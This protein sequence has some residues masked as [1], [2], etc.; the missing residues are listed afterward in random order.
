M[1]NLPSNDAEFHLKQVLLLMNQLTQW[2]VHSGVG[3]MEFSA[4]LKP[5]FYQQAIAELERIDQ[6]QTV[7]AI[8][9]LAGLHRKDVSAYKEM[10]LQGKPLA[11]ASVAEPMSVPARVV[12]LWIAED[13]PRQLVFSHSEQISFE[14]LVKKISTERHPRSVLNEL[15]RLGVVEESEDSV[16][17][18][19]GGFIPEQIQASVQLLTLHLQSHMHAGLHNI[20]NRNGITHLEE[21]VRVDELTAESVQVLKDY[22]VELWD[23]YSKKLMQLALERCDLDQD[24]PDALYEFCLG[25]YQDNT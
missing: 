22:S 5:V 18:K 12:G 3:Y 21:A 16:N 11:E 6:K 25:V 13:L 2:L 20:F 10:T 1:S 24:K 23:E 14:Y 4:A 15:V 8:S 19:K 17:L 7:S 9:L